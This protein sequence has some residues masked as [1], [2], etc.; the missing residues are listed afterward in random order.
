M[1]LVIVESPTKARTI[2]QYL[3]KGFVVKSSFGHVR[4]LPKTTMGVD[5][6]NDFKP[7]YVIPPKARPHIK[8][9]KQAARKAEEIYFATDEDR[10]GEAIAWHLQEILQADAK[11]VKRITFDEIT[12]PA[13]ERA[14][15]NPR[16]IDT[17]LVNA[18]QARRILDRLVGYE[19]SPLLWKK[20]R[21]GLSA[22]R[23]QSVALRL[24]VDREE[25]V[26]AFK[27]QEYW[28]IIAT[29]RKD[30]EQFSAKLIQ[31]GGKSIPKLGIAT[32]DEAQ[33]IVQELTGITYTVKKVQH[34]ERKRTPPPPFTTSTL[35]QAAFNQLG[36]SGKKAM[37]IA[38][39]LY[40][41]IELGRKGATGL[42]TYMRTDSTHLAHEATA[43]TQKAIIKLFGP[44]YA[45]PSP[46]TYAKKATHAQ[47]AHEAIRPTDPALT[48]EN[49]Q[50][51]LSAEQHKLYALI[52]QR[53]LACQMADARL[54][55]TTAD[56]AASRYIFRATGV[57][58]AFDGFLQVLGRHTV[59]KETILPVLQQGET[60]QLD[61]LEPSQHFT[62][63]PPRYSEATLVKALEENGIG[64]PSTY[65]PT[66]GIVQQREYAVKGS[67]RRFRPTDVGRIVNTLLTK[68]FANIVDI[69]F[70][71]AMEE[72][73]DNVAAG[74][75]QW[76]PVIQQFYQPFHQQI[77]HATTTLKKKD[78]T[79]QKLNEP[80]PKCGNQLVIKLG[81]FGK[82][83]ACSNF[84]TCTHTE[85]LGE[86][87]ELQE[88]AN[89]ETCPRCGK[90]LALRHGRFG[91]FLGCS[92]Y[93]ECTHIKK[94]QQ[95]T[96]VACPTCQKGE[97]VVKRSRKG[98]IFYGC[99]RY[100]ECKTAFWSKPTGETCPLCGNLLVAGPQD[101]TR[102]SN[103]ECKFTRE[104]TPEQA[105]NKAEV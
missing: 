15:A 101:T 49:I 76:Q 79:Q 26:E 43:K 39:Q 81:R 4:D 22:G 83:K 31:R 89:N 90:P 67:D 35:Q 64:R 60:L 34:T 51:Y 102:C 65:A 38:Q 87:K 100:P 37:V 24:I 28:T 84:P 7:K 32:S 44:S 3:G 1:K 104:A 95:G 94:V 40:E 74:R 86:E 85:P 72:D 17:S 58:V 46:R 6:A 13:I 29:L 5:I 93:P 21:R 70:T 66:I 2:Q 33:R 56:I 80:C 25:E 10:E 91:P 42:I 78:I 48:P 23:V 103:K 92:G 41:G 73:L 19:L 53:T 54:S 52:W 36:F 20:V 27:P 99:N 97:L 82:F 71:A 12:K 68:H 75:K 61:K 55:Q 69:A 14:L 96:G 62:Q 9:L 57:T 45:L 50:Q 105:D 63:P 98:K 18:Q 77:E 30:D 16:G 47:E 59:L 11:K 88:A 8:E